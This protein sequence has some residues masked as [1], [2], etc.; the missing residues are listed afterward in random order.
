MDDEIWEDDG[1]Y[2]SR[3]YLRETESK[4][5]Y[6]IWAGM[7]NRCHAPWQLNTTGRS[8]YLGYGGRGITVCLR[9]RWGDGERTGYDCFVAD[10]GPRPTPGHSVDRVENDGN[11]EPFN[12][13]WA[14]MDVQLKNRW[15][16]KRQLFWQC[17]NLPMRVPGCVIKM[18]KEMEAKSA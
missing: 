12:C 14:T 2:M 9:W 5:L 18:I 8:E 15:P 11:Y 16:R 3:S 17:R 13:R 7:I 4:P 1:Y 6:G 10:M